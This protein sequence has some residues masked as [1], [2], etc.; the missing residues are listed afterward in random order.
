MVPWRFRGAIR[1]GLQNK[2]VRGPLFDPRKAMQQ[3]TAVLDTTKYVYD[4]EQDR[5]GA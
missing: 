2:N 5:H 4:G 3:Q 1:D